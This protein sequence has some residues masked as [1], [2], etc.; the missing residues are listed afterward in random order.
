MT[1][2]TKLIPV[3]FA[4]VDDELFD[5]LNQHEWWCTS[6]GY[7]RCKENGKAIL[8]HRV[9]LGA[10]DD[11]IVDHVNGYGTDNQRVNLRECSHHQNMMNR[12]PHRTSKGKPTA[13]RYK[14]V[15]LGKN[16]AHPWRA[17]IRIDS[18]DYRI[19]NYDNEIAAAKAYDAAARFYFGEFA[20]TNFPGDLALSIEEIRNRVHE[21]GTVQL[22]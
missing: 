20:R 7:V 2:M 16:L 19:G 21:F 6:D 11:V 14:G 10:P 17:R 8:M 12:R 22:A 5:E 9:V 1:E 4:L 18:K 13:S 3:R 15:C